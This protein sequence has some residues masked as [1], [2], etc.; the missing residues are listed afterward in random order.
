MFHSLRKIILVI[1]LCVGQA[2]SAAS[3]SSNQENS[4]PKNTTTNWKKINPMGVYGKLCKAAM[5]GNIATTKAILEIFPDLIHQ[6]D[7][8]NL[9]TP[10][11][12]ACWE[13]EF[14]WITT[15]VTECKLNLD[16]TAHKN[17][18]PLH[19]ACMRGYDLLVRYLL[20]KNANKETK[21]S[22][23]YNAFELALIYGFNN[24]NPQRALAIAQLFYPEIAFRTDEHF[25]EKIGT[26]IERSTSK[27]N[28]PFLHSAASL[29]DVELVEFLLEL[30]YSPLEEDRRQRLPHEVA[31]GYKQRDTEAL[32]FSKLCSSNGATQDLHYFSVLA[33]SPK[34]EFLERLASPSRS[35]DITPPPS[36]HNS[37]TI[38]PPLGLRR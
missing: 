16:A 26:L 37:R 29:G 30:G 17:L 3:S 13:G 27:H 20:Q 22:S 32:L 31:D 18:T 9:W 4:Y 34:R 24:K 38:T 23:G 15:F 6:K 7:P 28:I 35:G 33:A 36:P 25:I 14:R 10:L 1:L 5:C 12:Y 8:N 19:I 21:T 2:H 11:H